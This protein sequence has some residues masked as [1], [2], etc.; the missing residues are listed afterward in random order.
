MS[1]T[2]DEASRLLL[3]APPRPLPPVPVAAVKWVR[4]WGPTFAP[5]ASCGGEVSDQHY[6]DASDVDRRVLHM[7]CPLPDV[8]P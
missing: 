4:G 7:M 3:E 6:Y 1:L 2:N 5:C 8:L